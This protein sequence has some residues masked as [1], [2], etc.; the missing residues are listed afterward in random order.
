[1]LHYRYMPQ[2][3]FLNLEYIFYKIYSFLGSAFGN[4]PS[5][6][7]TFGQWL[8]DIIHGLFSTIWF[9]AIL[10]TIVLFCVVVY[11][12]LEIKDID[13]KR[14]AK[15]DEHFIKPEPKPIGIRNT[16]WERIVALLGSHNPNDWKVAIIDADNML[17]EL[18]QSLGIPGDTLGERLKVAN[19]NRLLV[20]SAGEAHGIRNRI[21]HDTTYQLTDRDAILAKNLF[22]AVFRAAGII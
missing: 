6:G 19:P 4:G 11:I 7:R 21:A 14:K 12:K 8:S 18:T 5:G 10:A 20:K 1:M 2:V 16:R 15:H 22:E 9:I 17:D 13:K 3:R